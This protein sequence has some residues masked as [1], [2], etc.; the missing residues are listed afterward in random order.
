MAKMYIEDY[1]PDEQDVTVEQPLRLTEEVE[2]EAQVPKS[3]PSTE[4]VGIETQTKAPNENPTLPSEQD[5]SHHV[6]DEMVSEGD[7][8]R[9][10]N[11]RTDS[12][13]PDPVNK[14]LAPTRAQLEQ[15]SEKTDFDSGIIE[16][17]K[18]IAALPPATRAALAELF[19]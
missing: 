17:A 14:E 12:P 7:G 11:L 9:T 16:L 6:N 8:T 10:R 1:D 3:V 18:K 5:L 4:P 15:H 2:S 13:M 19:K